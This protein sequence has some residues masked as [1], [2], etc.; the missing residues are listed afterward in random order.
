MFAKHVK[1]RPYH[2]AEELD[3]TRHANNPEHKLHEQEKVAERIVCSSESVTVD[4]WNN[5]APVYEQ[6]PAKPPWS[7]SQQRQSVGPTKMSYNYWASWCVDLFLNKT[8]LHTDYTRFG[9]FEH[10]N[11]S[12]VTWY[13]FASTG[14]GWEDE[15]A[16]VLYA[17]R[18]AVN[19]QLGEITGRCEY[20]D[21]VVRPVWEVEYLSVGKGFVECW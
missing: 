20:F 14:I 13:E 2:Q 15:L 18:R 1:T 12:W 17:E 3:D 19:R 11:P 9:G 8:I 4:I 5:A 7:P 16:E 21:P 10:Y 6:K